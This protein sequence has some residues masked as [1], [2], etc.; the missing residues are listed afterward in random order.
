[1]KGLTLDEAINIYLRDARLSATTRAN[2]KSILHRFAKAAGGGKRLNRISHTDISDYIED[3]LRSRG[4]AQNSIWLYATQ[5]R[6]FFDFCVKA[7][8]I[9]YSP[10]AMIQISRA[11]ED[12]DTSR[13]V[14]N[15]LLMSMVEYSRLHC[16]RDYAMLLALMCGL[17]RMG[18]AGLRL[19]RINWEKSEATVLDKGNR[20]N[21]YVLSNLAVAALREYIAHH[22]KP[23]SSNHVFITLRKPYTEMATDSVSEALERLSLKVGAQQA[24]RSHAVRHWFTEQLR[25]METLELTIR[26]ALNHQSEDTTQKHYAR[27]NRTQVHQAVEQLEATLR[28]QLTHELPRN[29]ITVTAEE[30]I[31]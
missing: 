26:D 29:I 31:G 3:H 28:L 17:R 7:H 13:A 16:Y 12:P 2:V 19:D 9:P 20:Y 27:R 15:D 10:A 18:V 30:L 5:I 1:M 11:P 25:Q 4:L 21:T 14:P 22:R 6:T 23:S 24:Y 8:F